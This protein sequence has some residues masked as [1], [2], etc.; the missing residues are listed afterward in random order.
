MAGAR[1]G[2]SSGACG[3]SV[4]ETVTPVS[5]GV[6]IRLYRILKA[7]GLQLELVRQAVGCPSY[8]WRMILEGRQEP[9]EVRE[10]VERYVSEMGIVD[11]GADIWSRDPFPKR[12]PPQGTPRKPQPVLAGTEPEKPRE[13]QELRMLT[14][15]ESL[16]LEELKHF[17]LIE[18]PFD[19]QPGAD[20]W[21]GPGQR[22]MLGRLKKAV[23]NREILAVVGEVG[24]GKSTILRKWMAD[25]SADPS[26]KLV[27]PATLSRKDLD[28]GAITHAI[29]SAL[30][31]GDKVPGNREKRTLR[32][33]ELLTSAS[34]AGITP[35]LMIEEAHSLPLEAFITLKDLWDRSDLY[36]LLSIILVGQGNSAIEQRTNLNASQRD[37]AL[38]L[39]DVR[40]RELFQRTRLVK[41]DPM[42]SKE[43]G[44]F[45]RW[46]F[47]Q[48]KADVS[49][50]F[51]PE[52]FEALAAV[53]TCAYP[54][55]LGNVAILAM[56]AACNQ[57]DPKVVRG[58]IQLMKMG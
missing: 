25:A 46:R 38:K 35:V 18:D 9:H 56:R 41:M 19:D 57:G 2:I 31:P 55:T 7:R 3:V 44:D 14:T 58:H 27:L 37:L 4:P 20:L 40:I 32:V 42:G 53:K 1:R 6:M 16:T 15:R 11:E 17:E 21:M 33:R 24:S 13:T 28:E 51:T 45:L 30:A 48:V 34:Q 5:E 23:R 54:L 52:A 36:R 47:A 22:F 8:R 29:C 26:V 10:R 49:K 43:I 39:R 12:E 50:V